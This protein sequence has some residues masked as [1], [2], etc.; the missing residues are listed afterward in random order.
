MIQIPKREDVVHLTKWETD[1]I[2]SYEHRNKHVRELG[3]VLVTQELVDR[4]VHVLSDLKVLD[5]GAGTGYLS[6]LLNDKGIEIEAV[7]I[8]NPETKFQF[9][10]GTH[11]KV[12]KENAILRVKQKYYDVV[13]LAW[14][15][16]ATSFAYKVANALKQ[17]QQLLYCGEGQ[18]GCTGDD[19][20]HD[21]LEEKFFEKTELSGYLNEVHL[22]YNGIH[23]LW[24]WYEKR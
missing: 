9:K 13:M 14:P 18:G 19:K 10:V 15:S 23:D 2:S 8:A 3:F 7:D 5:A 11:F 20:F 24:Y 1:L 16:Y 21:L 4:L 17:T 6:Y 12:E 22:Q